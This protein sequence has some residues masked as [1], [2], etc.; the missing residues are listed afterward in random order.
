MIKP[1]EFKLLSI[2]A[3]ADILW[4]NGTCLDEVIEYGKFRICIYEINNFFVGVFYSVKN[5][6]IERVEVLENPNINPFNEMI[7]RN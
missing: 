3:R 2:N 4:K 5:N 1:E 7:Y 6:K